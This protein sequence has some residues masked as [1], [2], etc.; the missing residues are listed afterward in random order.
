[1]GAPKTPTIVQ[2]VQAP[3]KD[4]K[5]AAKIALDQKKAALGKIRQDVFARSQGLRGAASMYDYA[6]R[7]PHLAGDPKPVV[8]KPPAKPPVTPPP[9]KQTRDPWADRTTL[10]PV[11]DFAHNPFPADPNE[12]RGPRGDR[13]IGSRDLGGS[14]RNTGAVPGGPTLNKVY[15][16]NPRESG[17]PRPPAN[18][19]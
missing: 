2:Q 8:A 10:G 4:E 1:M 7:T 14:P 5:E 16:G 13:D 15:G 18:V 19:A 9:K 12:G 3:S 6:G 17:L 11:N